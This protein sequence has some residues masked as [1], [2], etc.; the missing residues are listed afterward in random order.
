MA[1]L[2]QIV[3]VV[4]GKKSDAE[5]AITEIYHKVQKDGLFA[6]ISKT[7][8]RLREDGEEL[9]PERKLV[10][11]RV[12]DAIREFRAA[13]TPVF[14]TTL[15]QDVGNTHA[16]ASVELDGKVIMKDV[17]VPHLLFLEKKLTDL[18]TFISKLPTLDPGQEWNFN[19]NSD[20]YETSP[21]WR[22]HTRKEPRRFEKSAATDK[23]PAQVEVFHE[24]VNVGKWIT[25]NQ[26][27]G[28]PAKDQ[29]AMLGRVKSLLEAVKKA[30]E[31]ANLTEVDQQKSGEKIFDY[32][33]DG[34]F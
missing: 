34:S 10:Q 33:F 5:K 20:C 28:I 11:Y 15:T 22:Y 30:R 32:V 7:Y 31:A 6:G 3:A 16:V 26:H 12:S 4:S 8:S 25:V 23:F 14:D 27:G 21:I 29:R 13:M 1:R 24:D 9:P 2:N 18:S 17:P 19:S